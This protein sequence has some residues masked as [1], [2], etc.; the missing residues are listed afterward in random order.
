MRVRAQVQGNRGAA[1]AGAPRGRAPA[2]ADGSLGS[3]KL[4]LLKGG[5]P[6]GEA[7]A[8]QEG[9]KLQRKVV[10]GGLLQQGEE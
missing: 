2:R 7:G 6:G 4:L 3:Q 1:G 9:R 8:L 10:A 5:S